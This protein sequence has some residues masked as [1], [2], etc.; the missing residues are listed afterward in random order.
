MSR[1]MCFTLVMRERLLPATRRSAS[2]VSCAWHQSQTL[3]PAPF[4]AALKVFGDHPF[5]TRPTECFWTCTRTRQ[6]AARRPCGAQ[7]RIVSVLAPRNGVLQGGIR[8]R[9]NACPRFS[10]E[11]LTTAVP[12]R[13]HDGRVDH[14]GP[15]ACGRFRLPVRVRHQIRQGPNHSSVRWHTGTRSHA[16]LTAAEAGARARLEMV[17][18]FRTNN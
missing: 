7:G 11:E 3:P 10:A 13:R 16:V 1:R 4:R 14:H 2:D 15:E 5:R 12:D 18:G 17:D 9:A 6:A 8:L